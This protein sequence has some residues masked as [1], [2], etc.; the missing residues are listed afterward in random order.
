MWISTTKERAE[1]TQV[2]QEAKKHSTE[3]QLDK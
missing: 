1:D 2:L 3:I